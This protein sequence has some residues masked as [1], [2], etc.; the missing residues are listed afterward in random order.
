MRRISILAVL[1]L[2]LISTNVMA[3]NFHY[4][5]WK[6]A[7][8]SFFF[9]SNEACVCKCGKPMKV[10][11]NCYKDIQHSY[12]VNDSSE[13]F[14]TSLLKSNL[15]S[16]PVN[17][18]QLNYFKPL[19]VIVSKNRMPLIKAPPHKSLQFISDTFCFSGMSL[20]LPLY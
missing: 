5:E 20:R 2:Y 10:K 15:P 3:L 9:K 1:S 8:F 19:P 11:S 13:R 14:N 17:I 6:L 7:G 18:S 4:C 12:L 16:V